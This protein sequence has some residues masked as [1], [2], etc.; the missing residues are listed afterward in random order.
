MTEFLQLVARKRVPQ[1]DDRGMNKQGERL[2]NLK[3]IVDVVLLKRRRIERNDERFKEAVKVGPEINITK[4]KYI[5]D[6]NTNKNEIQM[7][8]YTIQKVVSYI[9]LGN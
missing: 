2:N 4:I 7:E 1:M 9:F 8:G 3:F 5:A 6:G